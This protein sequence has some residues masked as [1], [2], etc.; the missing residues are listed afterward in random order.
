MFIITFTPIHLAGWL[1][2]S[3]PFLVLIIL[4]VI[5]PRFRPYLWGMF[6]ALV[7]AGVL[8]LGTHLIKT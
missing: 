4:A 5:A 3:S 7:I 2:L 8:V 6:I 1:L